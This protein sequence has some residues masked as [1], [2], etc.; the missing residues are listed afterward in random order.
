[1]ARQALVVD[2]SVAVKWFSDKDEV[3]LPQALSIRDKH[4]AGQLMIIVPDLFYYEVTNAIVNKK[5]IPF[6][7]VQD[8][9]EAL[10]NLGFLDVAIDT[11]LLRN[12]I[13]L[14]R[15]LNIAVK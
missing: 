12:S 6:D 2:A 10:F 14:A 7:T 11:G 3:F 15:Q 13:K 5:H 1:M 9:S 8:A 4:L